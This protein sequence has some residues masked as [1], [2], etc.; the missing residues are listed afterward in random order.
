[1][2]LELKE[3]KVHGTKEFPYMDY[4]VLGMEHAFQ[5]P[6]HWHDEIEIIYVLSGPFKV[7]IEGEEYESKKGDVFIVNP[8][9]LHFMGSDKKGADYHTFVFPLELISFMSEDELSEK[10][11]KPLRN[12]SLKFENVVDPKLITDNMLDIL[13]NLIL[14]YNTEGPAKYLQ[15]RILLLQLFLLLQDESML[16]MVDNEKNSLGRDI[17]TLIQQNYTE[18]IKLSDIANE[19][20]MSEKYISRYFKQSFHINLSQYV[21]HLRITRAK[22][23]LENTNLPITEVA[24][25][26]GF[27]EVSYFVRSFHKSVGLSP[28]Q[29]RKNPFIK[30]QK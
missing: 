8:G 19:L 15:I 16:C 5:I 18:D 2:Y 28:L 23:L 3:N 25:Q 27:S 4:H 26:S 29:Y 21:S 9:E 7:I 6:V 10:F 13:D 14:A 20:H 30:D 1:M 17:L 11:F 12:G 24:Y 22:H